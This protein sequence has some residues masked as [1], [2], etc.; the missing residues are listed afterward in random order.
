[1]SLPSVTQLPVARKSQELSTELAYYSPAPPPPP[2]DEGLDLKRVI[3]AVKRRKYFILAVVLLLTGLSY[4][5]IRQL[6]PI[7]EAK[8]TLLVQ[9]DQAQ[10][11]PGNPLLAAQNPNIEARETE[12]EVLRSR[13]LAGRVVDE[14]DLVASPLFNPLL[15]KDEGSV[16][17]SIV[18]GISSLFGGGDA[19][20]DTGRA[21]DAL[22]ERLIA[23]GEDPTA[24]A[25]PLTPEE[26]RDLVIQN[27]LGV[28]TV[29]PSDRAQTIEVIVALSDRYLAT[30]IANHLVQAYISSKIE[31]VQ[32]T[33]GGASAYLQQQVDEAEQRLRAAQQALSDYQQATGTYDVEGTTLLTTQVARL[34]ADLLEAR[35]RAQIAQA[36]YDQVQQMIATGAGIDSIPAVMDSALIASLRQQAADV[37]RRVAD[38]RTRY[39]PDY[40]ELRAAQAELGNLQASIGTE[41][42]KIGLR[43]ENDLQLARSNVAALEQQVAALEGDLEV[44][45]GSQAELVSLQ[46]QVENANAFYQQLLARQ[47]EVQT[48][49]ND[50]V[51]ADARVISEAV[52]PDQPA[53]PNTKLMLAAAVAGS[54][55]I[56]AVLALLAE[57]MDA[58]FRSMTQV[59]TMTG[60]PALGLMPMTKGGKEPHIVAMENPNSAYGEAVRSLRTALLLSSAD[61]PPRTVC[62][63]SSLPDEGKTSTALSIAILA[64]K[65]G[66]KAVILDCDL[67]RPSVHKVLGRENN[68]GLADYLTGKAKLAEVLEIDPDSDL[69]YIT[70]GSKTPNPPELLQSQTMLKL[71]AELSREYDLVVLDTPPIMAV[72]DALLLLRRCDKTVYVVRWE[73]TKRNTAVAGV[74]QAYDAG[75]DLAGVLL[76]QVNAKKMA[77]YDYADSG[78]YYSSAY[79]KYYTEDR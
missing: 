6:T 38:L 53:F 17:D 54:L 26:T 78:Y 58:G 36:A 4:L 23:D 70:A 3:G 76:T 11:L 37:E 12:A 40:P 68:A 59:E 2:E 50:T 42:R 43:L 27:L 63:T 51:Q 31:A 19:A 29:K 79:K 65:S 62:V 60:A 30:R 35:N 73:K 18:G 33:E 1:M 22:A 14:L 9:I 46:S 66:Q 49:T 24:V 7:Y 71:L 55:V 48:Q 44:Q 75:G 5:F 13:Q 45:S 57:F 32:A 77:Q 20:D 52:V 56:G 34:S 25:S 15:A 61:A 67:R 8:V 16:L 69:H 41:V 64:A 72:S 39:G 47:M 28:L 10:L 21:E 74:R